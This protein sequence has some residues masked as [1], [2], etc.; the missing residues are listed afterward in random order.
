M[1]LVKVLSTLCLFT[2]LAAVEENVSPSVVIVQNHGLDTA[3]GRIAFLTEELTP[4]VTQAD[5][6]NQEI[7]ALSTQIAQLDGSGGNLPKAEMVALGNE[8]T[9]KMDYMLGMLPA[10]EAAIQIDNDFQRIDSIL[11]KE[12]PLDASEIELLDRIASLCNCIDAHNL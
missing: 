12:E 6:L 2:G 11:A 9:Q 10:L 8:L 5:Q 7:Q 1:F 3:E 4:F